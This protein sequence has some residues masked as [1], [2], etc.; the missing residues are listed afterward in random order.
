MAD[1]YRAPDADQEAATAQGEVERGRMWL[2][3]VGAA[4]VGTR[5]LGLALRPSAGALLQLALASWL[6]NWSYQGRDS[7][8]GWLALLCGLAIPA[9]LVLHVRELGPGFSNWAMLAVLIID[10]VAA[11]ILVFFP[12][13][14]TFQRHQRE[15][16]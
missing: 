11:V 2:L 16:G 6:L 14:Q 5:V 10:A 13:I 3:A 8:R 12:S 7:A 1:P 4:V 15:R 9:T